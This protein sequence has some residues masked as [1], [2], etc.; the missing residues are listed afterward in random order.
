MGKENNVKLAGDFISLRTDH[1]IWIV[2][3][4]KEPS[5]SFTSELLPKFQRIRHVTR[6]TNGGFHCTCPY[7]DSY[8]IPCRHIVHVIQNYCIGVDYLFSHHDIDIRWWTTYSHFAVNADPKDLN[9]TE[10]RIKSELI[11]IRLLEKLQIGKNVSLKPF[12]GEV[13]VCAGGSLI[14][15]EF[16]RLTTSELSKTI[17]DERENLYPIN[18]DRSVV[19]SSL[20]TLDTSVYDVPV[21]YK[22]SYDTVCIPVAVLVRVPAVYRPPNA[23]NGRIR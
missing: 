15:E 17:F 8:G 19:K 18:Y 1:T 22:L 2:R 5:S 20:E 4:M 12:T 14:S 3:Q 11:R 23:C 10:T 6:D 7:T 21:M 13:E 16:Q 9:E